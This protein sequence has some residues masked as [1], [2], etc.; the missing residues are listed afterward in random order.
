MEKKFHNYLLN[1]L[2]KRMFWTSWYL[3]LYGSIRTS[4]GYCLLCIQLSTTAR[5]LFCVNASKQE[6]NNENEKKKKRKERERDP[7]KTEPVLFESLVFF[8]RRRPPS[9]LGNHSV[10]QSSRFSH[11]RWFN[12]SLADEQKVREQVVA[13]LSQIKVSCPVIELVSPR[14]QLVLCLH[15][16]T[17]SLE[18]DCVPPITWS[19]ACFICNT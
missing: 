3:N 19:S 4:H 9:S 2:F 13:G 17:G 15:G 7:E 1:Y 11:L 12:Y 6:E 16:F 10:C 18:A 8:V 14:G 5:D